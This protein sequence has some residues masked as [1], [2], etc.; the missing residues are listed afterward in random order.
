MRDYRNSTLKWNRKRH[1]GVVTTVVDGR[2]QGWTDRKT[3][4]RDPR[5]SRVEVRYRSDPLESLYT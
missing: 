3:S 2:V 4:R 1:M 5:G